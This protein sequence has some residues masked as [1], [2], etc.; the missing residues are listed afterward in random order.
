MADIRDENPSSGGGASCAMDPES[1]AAHYRKAYPSLHLIASGITGDPTHAHDIV[2]EAFVVALEKSRQF[3]VGTSY[4]AWLSE[5][6]RR[7]SLNYARKLRGR[8]TT[9]ADPNLLA[10]TKEGDASEQANWS[11]CV[12]TGELIGSQLDFD[13]EMMYAL[14]EISPEPRCCLL[15]RVLQNLSYAEIAD[16]MQIPE[17]TA[18]SHVHR[19]KRKLRKTLEKNMGIPK[20][21]DGSS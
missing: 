19:S 20:T 2:Q 21:I 14:E 13:D 1:V 10:L 4:K 16:L 18:M 3:I 12:K 5:I 7:I 8:K 17:G 9:P 6:V 15:L 11:I